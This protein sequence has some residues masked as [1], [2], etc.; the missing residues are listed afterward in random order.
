MPA[1][2]IPST[3]LTGSPNNPKWSIVA[4]TAICAT[5]THK[6]VFAT[7]NRGTNSVTLKI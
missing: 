5:T 2:R 6:I 4:E 7:P 3:A 1:K